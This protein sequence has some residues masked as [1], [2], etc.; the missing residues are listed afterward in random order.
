MMVP[1]LILDVGI[2]WQAIKWDGEDY[3]I[4]VKI[5]ESSN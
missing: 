5:L 1:D 4:N 3:G 2:Y